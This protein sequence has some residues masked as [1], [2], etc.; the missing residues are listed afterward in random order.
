MLSEEVQEKIKNHDKR[1][2][3]EKPKN[4]FYEKYAVKKI[5]TSRD[6]ESENMNLI[7]MK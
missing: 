4:E 1:I 7:K 6:Q 2:D 5:M 3:Y